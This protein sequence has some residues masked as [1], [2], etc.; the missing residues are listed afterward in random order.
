MIKVAL[1]ALRAAKTA[2]LLAKIGKRT[3]CHSFPDEEL[4]ILG[5][6]VKQRRESAAIYRENNRQDLLKRRFLKR[7]SLKNTCR[8]NL[9]MKS[10][11]RLL[12]RL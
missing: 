12:K 8:Q 10:S 9:V 5:K 4:K 3:G 6:L 7:M 2:F 11:L 1:E